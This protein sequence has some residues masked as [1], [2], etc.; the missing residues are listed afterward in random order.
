VCDVVRA[1]SEL[2]RDAKLIDARGRLLVCAQAPCPS[3][4]TVECARWLREVEAALPS[5]VVSA[6]DQGVDALDVVLFVD[7]EEVA[8]KLDGRPVDIDPGDHTLLARHG[9][10]TVTEQIL[11]RQGEKNRLVTLS[12]RPLRP[13]IAPPERA[14][15]EPPPPGAGARRTSVVPYVLAGGGLAAV[16][17]GLTLDAVATGELS[18]LRHT[19]APFCAPSL[20]HRSQVE[21]AVGDSLLAV[22]AATVGVAT[23]AW[24][25]HRRVPR[26]PTVGP[27]V[28]PT[29]GGGAAG[30][31]GRF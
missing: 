30:I 6:Q 28:V 23:L 21:M 10:A 15:P 9:D 16:A 29:P 11:V 5:I 31:S 22:G 19:C 25:R 24:I 18:T 3:I 17:V 7:G 27:F 4:T 12:L 1:R 8:T 2:R 20:L 13:V 26:P 14:T